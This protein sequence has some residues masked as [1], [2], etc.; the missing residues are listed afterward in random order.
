MTEQ[1]RASRIADQVFAF[2][3]DISQ[4]RR[5]LETLVGLAGERG[6][7]IN[8]SALGRFLEVSSGL[9]PAE[10][11]DAQLDAIAGASGG[12]VLWRDG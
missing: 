7:E 3:Q 8:V 2:I 11:T 12:K 1:E 9:V 6:Y 10:L 4:D 5:T